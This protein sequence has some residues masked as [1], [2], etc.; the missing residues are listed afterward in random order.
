MTKLTKDKI[1]DN[2]IASVIQETDEAFFRLYESYPKKDEND[3]RRQT[4]LHNMMF[5][6]MVHLYSHDYSVKDIVN[7]A[8][9][10]FD[11]YLDILENLDDEEDDDE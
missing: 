11:T 4:F 7:E 10:A 5:D 6:C 8:F 2:L 9:S 1:E 3:C